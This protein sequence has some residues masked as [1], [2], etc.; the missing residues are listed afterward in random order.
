MGNDSYFRD[1]FRYNAWANLALTESVA[2][3]SDPPARTLELLPHLV[4]AEQ[5]WMARLRGEH[6]TIEVWP[7]YS[8]DECREWFP[9]LHEA[10]ETYLDEKAG[11]LE[12]EIVAYTNTA[13]DSY[14]NRAWDILMHVLMHAVYHRGQIAADLKRHGF[15]PAYT[16]LIHYVRA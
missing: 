6:M 10:W 8:V 14:E 4:V 2:A 16:D 11:K 7:H 13:G 12:N 15:E 9:R 3:A 1:M 5:L